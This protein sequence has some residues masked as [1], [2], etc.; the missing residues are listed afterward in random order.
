M[1]FKVIGI[2]VT[3]G[4]GIE[5]S[6]DSEISDVTTSLKLVKATS[7]KFSPKVKE[8]RLNCFSL[9]YLMGE[10]RLLRV[11]QPTSVEMSQP[12]EKNH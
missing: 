10:L 3:Q 2:S 4:R 1:P 8:I 7:G 11:V 5:C 6:L 9:V 12:L